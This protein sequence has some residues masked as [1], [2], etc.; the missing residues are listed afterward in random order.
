MDGT[1]NK[2]QPRRSIDGQVV[3][4]QAII[5]KWLASCKEFLPRAKTDDL[6]V[7]DS[8]EKIAPA[9]AGQSQN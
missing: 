4:T 8:M 1:A 2:R 5:A 6:Q 7:S 3:A 9:G